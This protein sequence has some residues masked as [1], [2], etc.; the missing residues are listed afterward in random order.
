MARRCAYPR[1]SANNDADGGIDADPCLDEYNYSNSYRNLSTHPN[2]YTNGQPD[3]DSYINNNPTAFSSIKDR[4]LAVNTIRFILVCAL[5]RFIGY[6]WDWIG[7][8]S[9]VS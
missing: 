8:I 9:V 1:C 5:A 2:D 6:G 7:W 4:F 3:D